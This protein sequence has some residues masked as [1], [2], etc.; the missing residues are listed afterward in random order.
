MCKRMCGLPT[1][2][3]AVLSQEPSEGAVPVA[4][5][6][7]L[8]VKSHVAALLSG[9][10]MS[11]RQCDKGSSLP[12]TQNGERSCGFRDSHTLPLARWRAPARYRRPEIQV[13][14][15]QDRGGNIAFF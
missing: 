5:P 2:P 1:D 7:L 4:S 6:L 12:V 3:S 14:Y 15:L 10:F 9:V 13:S 11:A 8:S